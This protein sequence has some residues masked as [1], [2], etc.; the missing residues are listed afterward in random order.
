MHEFAEI[1]SA[2]VLPLGHRCVVRLGSIRA[3]TLVDN[4]DGDASH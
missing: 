2:F 1:R 3:Y 4:V